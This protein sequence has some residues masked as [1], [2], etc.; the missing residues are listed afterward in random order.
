MKKGDFRKRLNGDPRRDFEL[1][2]SGL[3]QKADIGAR[4]DHVRFT[5]KSGHCIAPQR[6]SAL[7]QKQTYAVQQISTLFDHLV[8][9]LQERFSN[10]QAERLGCLQI[11]NEFELYWRLHWQISWPLTP[12]NAIHVCTCTPADVDSIGP[13]GHQTSIDGE[14]PIRGN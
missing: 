7:C 3:D 8:A 1:P 10:R 13:I 2:M 11:D 4:L 12:E 6:M 9:K 5:P 14:L